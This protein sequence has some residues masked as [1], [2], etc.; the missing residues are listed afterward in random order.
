MQ[1]APQRP[2]PV[3]APPSQA[4]PQHRPQPPRAPGA[5]GSER[6][7]AA[8]GLSLLAAGERW[9]RCCYENMRGLCLKTLQGA[10]YINRPF[11]ALACSETGPF[12]CAWLRHG[13]VTQLQELFM[14]GAGGDREA[15]ADGRLRAAAQQNCPAQ[16]QHASTR[17]GQGKSWFGAGQ[18]TAAMGMARSSTEQAGWASEMSCGARPGASCACP[19]ASLAVRLGSRTGHPLRQLA[20]SSPGGTAPADQGPIRSPV[21]RCFAPNPERPLLHAHRQNLQ[22]QGYP[23]QLPAPFSP[24]AITPPRER[25]SSRDRAADAELPTG[26]VC[27]HRALLPPAP[28][29]HRLPGNG[30][31]QGA[32]SVWRL[33]QRDTHPA[34][35]AAQ[36]GSPASIPPSAFAAANVL[37]PEQ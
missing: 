17:L 37:T 5:R 16:P 15:P 4:L 22:T 31:V 35:P 3:P 34:P 20:P 11:M 18:R 1:Q 6:R 19:G 27:G 25:A 32:I 13:G 2:R 30:A 29:P 12:T 9:R 33:Q 21:P 8:K 28:W 24:A 7:T 26:P 10:S 36:G 14:L 23:T